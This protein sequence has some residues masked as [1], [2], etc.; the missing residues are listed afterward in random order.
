MRSFLSILQLK[1]AGGYILLLALLCAVVFLVRLEHGKMEELDSREHSTNMRRKAVNRTFEKLLEFSFHDHFLLMQD[2]ADIRECGNSCAAALDALNGLKPYYAAEQHPAIDTVSMLLLEKVGLADKAGAYPC[3]FHSVE[4][5]IPA[6]SATNVA[7]SL[8]LRKAPGIVRQVRDAGQPDTP[9]AK[10]GRGLLNVLIGGRNKKSAYANRK[11]KE[12]RNRKRQSSVNG[13]F[14]RLQKDMY[15]QYADYRKRLEACSDSLRCRNRELDARISGLIH[16]FERAADM[17]YTEDMEETAALRRQSFRIILSIAVISVLLIILLYLLIHAD[18]RKR[19]KYRM[20]LEA[21][22]SRNEEL[23]VSRRNLMLSVS[24]DLRAPLGTVCEFAE[25][26]Q[27]EKDAGL[28]REFAANILHASRHVIGLA[29]NLLHYYRLEEGKEQPENAVFHLG[30]TIGNAVRVYLPSAEKKGLG[31]T[32]EI[33]SCDVLVRGDSGRLVRILGN[34]LSNAVKFTRTGYIHVGASYGNGRLLLFVRDTGT[35]IDKERQQ[36]IFSDF[37]QAGFPTDGGFGLGLAVTSRLVSLLGGDIRVESTPGRGS[38]FEVRLPLGEADMPDMRDAASGDGLPL[39]IRVLYIDDDRMQLNITKEMFNRNGVRCDCCQTSREL[40]TR[41]RSQ[42]YDLLLTDIQ[43]PETDGYGILELLRASN[44]ENAKTIPVIAVT[45][46]VDDDNEYLSGGFSGCIHKPFS[47]EE[48][49]NT[50]AQVIGEKDRKEYAPDFS[51]ILSGEDNREEMLALFIEE[52]RKD[53]AALTA[54]LDRQDKEAAASIL[55][56]N[57][58]LWETVR[59]DFPLSHLRELVTEPATE[60]TNRQSM[61]M[62][63]IIRAVEKLIVY[64]EK[65]GRKAY[66]NNPDY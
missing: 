10:K 3:T 37:E 13:E 20:T 36:L 50:V 40:V 49:I 35:G 44:M 65:Y 48:L 52:S 39:N 30:Q 56:K 31:L 6:R 8:L 63:D 18:I 5:L 51:L 28:V 55:H 59:L 21:A 16:D 17:Q 22:C 46:R 43:M 24:H 23:L 26:M 11:E 32:T 33:K 45:A 2:S 38:T 60:W 25:L 4:R 62:R 64:A 9:S 47:M 61:E 12:M 29:N 57:L 19:Q 15:S 54:A 14:I 7:D 1:I 66:E 42:R 34:L 41:L 58:P 27:H 53:L